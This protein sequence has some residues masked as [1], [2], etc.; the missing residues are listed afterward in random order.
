[1]SVGEPLHIPSDNFMDLI[2]KEKQW[3]AGRNLPPDTTAEHI[4]QLGSARINVSEF[5]KLPV[6]KHDSKLIESL[7]ESFDPRDKW[8]MCPTL[9]EIRDQ[10]QCGA[11]WAFGA[12]EAMTDRVCIYSNGSKNFHFAAE[13]VLTC[14]SKGY[15]CNGGYPMVAWTEWVNVGLV[16]GGNYNSHQGCKPYSFAPCA[17]HMKKCTKWKPTP[18]CMHSC[19][20]EYNRSYINDKKRGKSFYTVAGEKHIMAELYK[21]GPAEAMFIVYEDFADYNG[22]VYQHIKGKVVFRHAVKLMGWGVENCAKY[23]LAAN[24]WGTGFGE[25]GFFKI[26]RGVNECHIENFVL[27]GEPLLDDY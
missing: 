16:S 20:N 1:M 9:N 3:E 22:G 12:V 15:G 4:R 21:N 8:P 13:D 6:M 24:S 7:P 11:C 2:S 17:N 23:W 18:R 5:K 19:E 14:K 26:L 25:N 10:G 27:A